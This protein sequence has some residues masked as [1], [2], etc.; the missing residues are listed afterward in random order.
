LE[1][2][3]GYRNQQPSGPELV[4]DEF[5]TSHVLSF[6]AYTTNLST[7]SVDSQLIMLRQG[8]GNL[9]EKYK[10]CAPGVFIEKVKPTTPETPEPER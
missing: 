4:V 3:Q 2:P 1:A 5:L 9:R 8:I 10:D 7:N 6:I